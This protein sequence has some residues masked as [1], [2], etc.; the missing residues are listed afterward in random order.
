MRNFKRLNLSHRFQ[1]LV[2]VYIS[3][4]IITDAALYIEA[5]SLA[6]D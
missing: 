6:D 1:L 3:V 2:I 4:C 5:N